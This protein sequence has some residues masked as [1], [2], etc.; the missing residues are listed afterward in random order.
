MKSCTTDK[1]T[2]YV[3]PTGKAG[4]S[5]T[6]SDPLSSISDALELLRKNRNGEDAELILLDGRYRLDGEF[7]LGEEDSG[8]TLRAENPGQ[9]IL[10]RADVIPHTRL[11][12]AAADDCGG[13]LP[14]PEKT[15]C[16]DLGGYEV[17]GGL[18]G[19]LEGQPRFYATDDPNPE[20]GYEIARYPNNDRV[21]GQLGG[22]LWTPE[23]FRGEGRT[24][25]F[26]P[27][28]DEVREH[29]A[30]YSERS[31]PE[32]FVKGYINQQWLFYVGKVTEVDAENG[33][34]STNDVNSNAVPGK[35]ED[36]RR[37][38]FLLNLPE[39][40]DA[41]GEYY[42]D[43][44][45]K[46]FY[47]IP[48]ADFS[49]DSEMAFTLE[50]GGAMKL[51]GCRGVTVSGITFRGFRR[52]P[53][54]A[55][56]CTDVLF[57]DCTVCRTASRAAYVSG[58]T[59]FVFDSCDFY[60][61]GCGAAAFFYCGDRPTLTRAE[62]GVVNCRFSDFNQIHT[63]YAPAVKFSNCCG[64]FVRQSTISNSPHNAIHFEQSNDVL[65]EDS[66]F[67][68]VCR[69]TD[70]ASAIYWGR[71]PTILG[72]VIRNNYFRDVGYE[73]AKFLSSAVYS[74]DWTIGPELYGNVFYNCC[75]MSDQPFENHFR[76]AI[77]LNAA[78][79]LT[80]YNNLFILCHP[81]QYPMALERGKSLYFWQV[82]VD[83]ILSNSSED[84][85]RAD[86]WDVKL[87]KAGYFTE[88]WRRHYAHT[89]WAAMYDYVNAGIREK[90]RR[91][92]EEEEKKGT[93]DPR[94]AVAD[95][96]LDE[97]FDRGWNRLTAD[98]EK[99]SGS[100]RDYCRKH[101][102]DTLSPEALEAPL[103]EDGGPGTL[104]GEISRELYEDKL[105]FVSSNTF[106]E[107]LVIGLER[108]PV[109]E[110]GRLKVRAQNGFEHNW[111]PETDLLESGNRMLEVNG[112]DFTL[113]EEG[114]AEIRRH[115]PKFHSVNT[116]DA[117]AKR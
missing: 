17:E 85:A 98:G 100:F 103:R 68:N 95:R 80:A 116:A 25:Q 36:E 81:K 34:V 26:F 72:V 5:G 101:Y 90:F 22:W 63:V 55:D 1:R 40:L 27:L 114:M 74:D 18:I 70:D 65:I 91:R 53:I 30:R 33:T 38:F 59:S 48:Q 28:G 110:N 84:S 109:D 117:V 39:E 3:S 7:T 2:L 83:G 45:E 24:A 60:D 52:T 115:L 69:D 112:D 75:L 46:K 96:A 86:M 51:E 88:T 10:T 93:E 16:L 108:K 71:D 47:F 4:A 42:Y 11:S 97:F 61:L 82:Y 41:E 37:R 105:A 76:A 102:A 14:C 62:C 104:I 57:K 58:S 78:Q 35:T 66:R 87:E 44:E 15:L 6:R 29:L 67:E 107:N 32:A 99:F 56:R 106:T 9:A 13:R 12:E 94:R 54:N 92:I 43:A 21:R 49:A 50:D 89:P 19:I 64:V 111:C 8:L 20:A 73:N 77:V 113:T 23:T 79:F 31:V